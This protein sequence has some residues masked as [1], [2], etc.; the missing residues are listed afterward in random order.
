MDESNN[1]AAHAVP[2]AHDRP[3]ET[4]TVTFDPNHGQL[5]YD[6]QNL[7]YATAIQRLELAQLF[8]FDNL[9]QA[10][11]QKENQIER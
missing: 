5:R 3:I 11:A 8:L 1:G 9:K 10:Q 4:I 7:D 2:H 6:L